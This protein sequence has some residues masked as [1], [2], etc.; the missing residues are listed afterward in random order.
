MPSTFQRPSHNPAKGLISKLPTTFN[1]VEADV[2]ALKD[3]GY[4]FYGGP[5]VPPDD[6]DTSFQGRLS[7]RRL[8]SRAVFFS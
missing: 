3:M 6:G 1:N 8:L 7:G 5:N 4:G 2:L